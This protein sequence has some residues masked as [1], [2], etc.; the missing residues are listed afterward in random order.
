LKISVRRG[1]PDHVVVAL[2]KAEQPAG[3]V[4]LDWWFE[5]YLRALGK[6]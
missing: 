1:D 6:S 3:G 2:L 5:T 4:D